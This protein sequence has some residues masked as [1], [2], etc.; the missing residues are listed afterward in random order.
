MPRKDRAAARPGQGSW[1][2]LIDVVLKLGGHTMLEGGDRGAHMRALDRVRTELNSGRLPHRYLDRDGEPH[3][4]DL[5]TDVRLLDMRFDD[6]IQRRADG[7]LQKISAL[8]VEVFWPDEQPEKRH[9][10]KPKDWLGAQEFLRKAIKARGEKLGK[11]E[12]QMI[13]VRDE[14]FS[15]AKPK[16]P[17]ERTLY[18]EVVDPVRR[19]IGLSARRG[20]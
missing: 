8:S 15:T 16:P 18:R 19:E 20:E 14:F 12:A 17:N 3:E 2:R 13:A 1:Q 9:G 7:T 5:P 10:P 6:C 11:R 4:N